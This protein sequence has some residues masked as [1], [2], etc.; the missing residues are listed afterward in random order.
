MEKKI[1]I[2][3]E[4]LSKL[5][6]KIGNAVNIRKDALQEVKQ[7]ILENSTTIS[8]DD[9]VEDRAK[10]LIYDLNDCASIIDSRVFGLPIMH[11]EVVSIATKFATDQFVI[12]ETKRNELIEQFKKDQ[13]PDRNMAFHYHAEVDALINLFIKKTTPKI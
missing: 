5:D 11:K 10:K 12:S 6:A 9:S 4:V 8:I 3:Q 1:V 13:L 7:L 2:D